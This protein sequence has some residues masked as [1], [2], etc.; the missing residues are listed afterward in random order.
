MVRHVR[1][2]KAC[3][4]ACKCHQGKHKACTCKA[5]GKHEGGEKHESHEK[6]K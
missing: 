1:H 5:K 3:G 6:G 2:H 4:K